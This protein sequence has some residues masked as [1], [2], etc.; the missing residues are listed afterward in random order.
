MERPQSVTAFGILNIVFAAWGV[1]SLISTTLMLFFLKNMKGLPENPALKLMDTM[2][3]YALWTKISLF[4][5]L[6]FAAVQLIAGIGLMK[7][8]PWGRTLSIS[9][10]SAAMLF[11]VTAAIVN[12]F[13]IA[14]PLMEEASSKQGPEQAAAIGASMAGVLGGC[15]GMIYPMLLLIFMFRPNV[16][17]AFRVVNSPATSQIFE[18]ETDSGP[19][20]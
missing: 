17:A 13:V 1:L 20:P 7:M 10:A 11:G 12:Y 8:R 6:I 15:F 9:Y 2:P 3:G 18:P 5:A 4:L 14:R 16:V 19:T